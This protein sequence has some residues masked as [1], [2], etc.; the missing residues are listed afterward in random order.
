MP[1]YEYGE[2]GVIMNHMGDCIDVWL[3]LCIIRPLS[4]VGEK[5]LG[6]GT[7][8]SFSTRRFFHCMNIFVTLI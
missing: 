1:E 6:H 4:G 8:Y 7:V 5:S 3:L 2:V